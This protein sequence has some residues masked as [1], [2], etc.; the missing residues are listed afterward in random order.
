MVHTCEPLHGPRT[1]KPEKRE[2]WHPIGFEPETVLRWRLWLEG[3]GVTQP[4]KQAYREVYLLT[5]EELATHTYSNRL[6]AHILLHACTRPRVYRVYQGM[7]T[8]QG[9]SRP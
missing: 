4:F 3:H 9:V 1:L 8:A 7:P 5:D 2:L 6:A